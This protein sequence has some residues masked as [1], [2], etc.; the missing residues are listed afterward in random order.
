MYVFAFLELASIARFKLMGIDISKVTSLDDVDGIASFF[1]GCFLE[2]GGG[3][4]G[5]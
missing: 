5:A 1:G 3:V 4:A 2:R